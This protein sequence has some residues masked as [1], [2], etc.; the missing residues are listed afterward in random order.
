MKNMLVYF[1]KQHT[2]I[3]HWAAGVFLFLWSAYSE[4]PPF[5]TLVVTMYAAMSPHLRLV[6]V[7]A[8]GLITLYHN[9][10][11]VA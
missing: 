4:V 11:R 3:T 1:W 2:K 5:H 10:K 7:A 6:A 9:G 8:L